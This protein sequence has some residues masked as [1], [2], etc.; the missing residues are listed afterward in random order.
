MCL[1]IDSTLFFVCSVFVF[2]QHVCVLQLA[3]GSTLKN[4]KSAGSK[5][6]TLFGRRKNRGPS[7]TSTD[8]VIPGVMK[9]SE[10]HD[11]I[12]STE[13]DTTGYESDDSA[14]AYDE[15]CVFEGCVLVYTLYSSVCNLCYV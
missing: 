8:A 3:W 1:C 4:M 5:I 11:T 2:N 12:A 15:V 14:D 10:S 9:P 13:E 7:V 6:R